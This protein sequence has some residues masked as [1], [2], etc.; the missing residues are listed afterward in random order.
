M[1]NPILEYILKC[2][3]EKQVILKELRNFIKKHLPKETIEKIS[4]GMPTFYLNKNI[5]H[6]M[7]HKY[8]IGIY[9]GVECIKFFQKDFDNLNLKYSKGAVQFSL[10]KPIPYNLLL[11]IINYN[12]KR[13]E[14]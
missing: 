5:I 12:L 2:N 1:N 6:F 3:Q 13:R 7:V 10:N 8:H 9:P 14:N 11:K 4:W